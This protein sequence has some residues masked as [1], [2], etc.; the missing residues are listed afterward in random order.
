MKVYLIK[1]SASS[2]FSQYKKESG[3][4]PQNIFSTA[5]CTPK[6]IEIEMAD[7]TIGMKA[8]LK[9]TADLV[10]IFMSTPDAI[11]AYDLAEHYKKAGKTVVLGGL[12]TKFCKE[13]AAQYADSLLIGETEE[14]WEELLEDYKSGNLKPEYERTT[15]FDLQNLKPYPLDI[16]SPSKYNYVWSVVVSRGCPYS[17]EFCLVP[18]FAPKYRTRPIKNIVDE[19]KQ[20]KAQGIE[21]MELHSDNLTVDRKFALELFRELKPLNLNFIA[22]TTIKIADDDELLNAAAEAGI[23]YFL[24]GLETIS[25]DAL[26]G[27]NKSFVEPEKIAEQVKKIQKCGIKVGSDFLFGFDEHNE[28]IFE[29]TYEA[30]KQIKP[31][32]IYPHLL[33][34]FPGSKMYT[35]LKNENRIITEDWS[36]YDGAHT[37]YSPKQMTASQL[38]E[39]TYW[40]WTKSSGL[41][42]KWYSNLFN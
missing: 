10:A 19:I 11:R 32:E 34:P 38:E 20:I 28:Y 30:L 18:E 21:W 25:K 15:P 35:R 29:E 9:S 3:G 1:A 40:V 24:F 39:G 7:E 13:E 23:K 2:S 14:I 4:P 36:K 33:I 5:A 22:E 8:N 16:I 42:K 6:N 27:M 41:V 26:K 37:V 31:D 12:H 17:C